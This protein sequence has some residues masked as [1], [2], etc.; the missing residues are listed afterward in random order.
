MNKESGQENKRLIMF[1]DRRNPQRVT[2]IRSHL[3]EKEKD[4]LR[5]FLKEYA[6]IFA[7]T[8][9]DMLGSDPRVI[10]HRLA[11][12]PS[13]K[14]IKQKRRV[15]NQKRR[16]TIREEVDKLLNERFIKEVHYP[17]WIANMVMVRKLNRK[18]RMCVDFIDLNKACPKIG[19][20]LPRIDQLV[21]S[22]AGLLSFMDAFSGYN[23]I[24]MYE[25]DHEKTAFVTNQ[26]L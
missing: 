1:L 5:K 20:P 16:E 18:W 26:G 13:F 4:Q 19:F 11:I 3:P 10:S 8:L 23:Q 9:D 24:K 25:L 17:E 12:N 7:W 21:D 22:T 2:K 6:D 15:F 14:P